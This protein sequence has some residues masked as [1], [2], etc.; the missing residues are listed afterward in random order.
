MFPLKMVDLSIA[1]LVHQRVRAHTIL[2]IWGK[3]QTTI[4]ET[5]FDLWELLD[6]GVKYGDMIFTNNG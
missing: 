2:K 4:P 1:M 5:R 6:K 3:Y